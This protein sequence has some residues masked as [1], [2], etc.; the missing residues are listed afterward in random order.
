MKTQ[1]IYVCIVTFAALLSGC[2]RTAINKNQYAL[3]VPKEITKQP[4]VQGRDIGA[5]RD[6]SSRGGQGMGQRGDSTG[7]ARARTSDM[8]SRGSSSRGGAFQDMDRGSSARNFSS[9]G[10]ASRQSMS[11]PSGGGRGGGG[12]GGGGRGGGGRR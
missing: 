1:H 8:R 5:G 9:R 6:L 2:G 10:Q 12:R 11:R 4:Q 7:A 3:A